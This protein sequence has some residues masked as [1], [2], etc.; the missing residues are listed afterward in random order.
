MGTP[1]Q[2]ENAGM[3]YYVL[4]VVSKKCSYLLDTSRMSE[5][6]VALQ[7]VPGNHN[8]LLQSDKYK[9]SLNHFV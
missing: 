1:V 8:K 6:Y 3:F 7:C 5:L 2:D 4:P 9:L